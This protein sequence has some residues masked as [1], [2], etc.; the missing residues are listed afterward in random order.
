MT[1]AQLRA[2]LAAHGIA[3]S[4]DSRTE[5]YRVNFRDGLELTAYYTDHKQDAHDTGLAMA[6]Q[7]EAELAQVAA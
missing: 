5:E 2:A 7:R 4:Y 6:K 3:V 1:F